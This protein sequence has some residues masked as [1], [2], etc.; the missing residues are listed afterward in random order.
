MHKIPNGIIRTV[1]DMNTSTDM[2]REM[3]MTTNKGKIMNADRTARMSRVPKIV[4]I[5]IM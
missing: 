1:I 4:V 3:S 5:E 2:D